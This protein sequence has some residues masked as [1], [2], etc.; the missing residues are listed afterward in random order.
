MSTFAI[1]LEVDDDATVPDSFL[2][3]GA[4]ALREDAATKI[5]EKNTPAAIG[6]RTMSPIKIETFRATTNAV[7][8][9]TSPLTES[10][11][12]E[13]SFFSGN[14]AVEI[15]RGFL[16]L[17]RNN[18]TSKD[19]KSREVC[20]LA[21]PAT[22]SCRDLLQFTAALLPLVELVRIIRDESPNQYMAL[23][24]FKDEEAAKKFKKTF[25]GKRFNSFE[26]K[27]CQLAFVSRV[28]AIK[29]SKG[30]SRPIKG[31]TELPKCPVCLERL[32]ES[33]NT[34]LTVLCNHSFHSSCLEQWKDTTCPVCRYSQSPEPLSD[35]KCSQCDA[36]EDIWICLICGYIGCGRY[37]RAHAREHYETTN[38]TFSMQLGT[39][40]V[41]DYTGDNYVHRLIQN[42]GDGKLVEVEGHE[43]MEEKVDSLTLEYTHLLTS[44]LE[45]QRHYFEEKMARMEKE[46]L[47]QFSTIEK[48]SKEQCE[49]FECQIADHEKEKR[50]QE[51]KINQLA[52]KLSKCTEQLEEEKELNKC[53]REN[54]RI[55]Q[56]KCQ[57]LESVRVQREAVQTRE[58]EE[59]REQ[60]RDLM[61]YM[62]TQKT[63]EEAPEETR[64]ELQE[65]TIVV[66]EGSEA[67]KST[68]GKKKPKG[69]RK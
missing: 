63:I 26:D 56:E 5:D 22:M 16:H 41:W 10:S 61:F 43:V 60:V 55:W 51:K 15:T 64:Q 45:S 36:I 29:S 25:N 40:R 62:E 4:A 35:N 54:Q 27:Y 11:P 24:R 53:L 32:D 66:G 44:Q 31:L 14:P 49:R 17:Y 19:V 65:G 13:I 20:L 9:K 30:A 2:Q 28:E 7:R 46:S 33:V 47:D 50:V 23:Y 59:L 18:E 21:V 34:V 39:G 48:K 68:I 12:G 37:L 6:K 8:G 38:H 52:G 3:E 67:A 42:K 57:H 1:R 58:V 69:K